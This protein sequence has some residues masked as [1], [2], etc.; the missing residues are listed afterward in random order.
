MRKCLKHVELG[1]NT[2]KHV[3]QRGYSAGGWDKMSPGLFFC[4]AGLNTSIFFLLRKVQSYIDSC[5][6]DQIGER[7]FSFLYFILR[8]KT[9][10]QNKKNV[11]H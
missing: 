10:A 6:V 5:D 4:Y 2:H 3:Q 8:Q 1:N 9:K 7:F 11:L